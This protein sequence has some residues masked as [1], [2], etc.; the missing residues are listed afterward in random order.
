[1]IVSLSQLKDRLLS[2]GRQYLHV[3]A[4][5][6]ELLHVPTGG[7]VGGKFPAVTFLFVQGRLVDVWVGMV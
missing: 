6:T 2:E 1:M 4:Q 3:E 5:G 7:P